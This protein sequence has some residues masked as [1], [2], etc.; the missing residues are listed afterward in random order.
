MYSICLHELAQND[1]SISIKRFNYQEKKLL[2]KYTLSCSSLWSSSKCLVYKFLGNIS[3][4]ELFKIWIWIAS[5][6]NCIS[7]LNLQYLFRYMTFF[8]PIQWKFSFLGHSSFSA[9]SAIL[10][11]RTEH[12]SFSI[13]KNLWNTPW[14]PCRTTW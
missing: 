7:S 9:N 2:N 3:F 8:R 10:M 6:R 14:T 4:S 1:K 11:S 13:L 5:L 12:S